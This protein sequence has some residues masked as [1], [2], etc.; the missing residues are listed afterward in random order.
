[1]MKKRIFALGFFLLGVII[2]IIFGNFNLTGDVISD[3]INFSYIPNVI[4]LTLIFLSLILFMAR[5]GIDAI[6]IPTGGG[7]FDEKE[8]MYQMDRDRARTALEHGGD[9]EKEGYFVISGYMGGNKKEISEGQSYS[10]YKFLRRHGIKPSQM[11]VEGKSHD[12]LQN[13][14]YT[15]KKIKAREQK[16]GDEKPWDVAFVSYP[17]HLNRF[18][19]FVK[20]AEKKGIV[21]QGDFIF[22]KIPTGEETL[23]ERKYENNLLRKLK[24]LHKLAT[25]E[26]YK[27]K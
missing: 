14:V 11:M 21:G 1:M 25:M 6:V 3:Y 8:G 23:E 27:T 24:H 9:L 18:E 13:V 26:R 20:Q 2:L 4:A 10:I 12:T 17:G 15:L 16:E 5:K 19:D 7:E 22:H